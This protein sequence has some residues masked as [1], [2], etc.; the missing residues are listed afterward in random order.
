M[1][2]LATFVFAKGAH[3]WATESIRA[4]LASGPNLFDEAQRLTERDVAGFETGHT[5]D[6]D[7]GF[8][9]DAEP[10]HEQQKKDAIHT[11]VEMLGSTER[12]LWGL[13]IAG[14]Y[15]QWECDTKQV[16]HNLG[17]P[18]QSKFADFDKIAKAV[19]R[20]GF[21]FEKSSCYERLNTVRYITNTIKHGAGEHFAT[22]VCSRPD[23]LQ[24]SRALPV[25]SRN[26]SPEDLLLNPEVFDECAVVI[27]EFW[28]EFEVAIERK[29]Q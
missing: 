27:G 29:R 22:L 4:R 26:P 6:P 24:G 13:G 18:V 28:T 5:Y 14:L 17:T 20:A 15:H 12:Y 16:L 11:Y 25:G 21:E 7:Y 2:A 1:Q 19:K 23:L 3:Q 8:G 10:T 9:N